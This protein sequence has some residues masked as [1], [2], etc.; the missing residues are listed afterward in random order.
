M[1]NDQLASHGTF[2]L[3]TLPGLTGGKDVALGTTI[4]LGVDG[5][6]VA[7]LAQNNVFT[8]AKAFQ[9]T[10]TVGDRGT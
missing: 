1:T 2:S 5:S 3:A 4:D 8:A 10:V 7:L 9:K 6:V